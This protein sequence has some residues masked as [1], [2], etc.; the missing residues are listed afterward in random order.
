MDVPT[1]SPVRKAVGGG[2]ALAMQIELG[3]RLESRQRALSVRRTSY[4]H[5]QDSRVAVVVVPPL[6]APSAGRS[7]LVSRLR[8]EGDPQALQRPFQP[9]SVDLLMTPDMFLPT[10][11][12]GV[13]GTRHRERCTLIVFMFVHT[14][15]DSTTKHDV[16]TKRHRKHKLWQV[17][18][19]ALRSSLSLSSFCVCARAWLYLSCHLTP[20]TS[21]SHL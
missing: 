20:S 19:R 9:R 15:Y 11:V 6:A 10:P 13:R 7:I 2:G 12:Q 1:N 16:Q 21:S 17:T 5:G 14:K 8:Y 18:R 4:K 3:N